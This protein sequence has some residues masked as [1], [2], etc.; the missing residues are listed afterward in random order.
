M[1]AA[2]LHD[3]WLLG[4][5]DDLRRRPLEALPL[6]AARGPVVSTRVLH[7]PV[8]LVSHP[9]GVQQVFTDVHTFDKRT[10][11]YRALGLI[12]GE[13]LV[14][15]DGEKW[16]R[17]RRIAQPAFHRR[18]IEG[19]AACMTDAAL[20]AA[21]EWDEAARR[22]EPV[23]AYASLTRLSLR[24]ACES[25]L[26]ADETDAV[27]RVTTVFSDL[28]AK[29]VER[30]G[31]PLSVPLWIPTPANRRFNAALAA[32][33]E[34]VYGLIARRRAD[35][36]SGDRSDILS[37]FLNA[38]DEETGEGMSDRELRD[39][40]ST[41]LVAG[42]ETT[43]AA[44]AWTFHLL[45]T[46]PDAADRLRAELDE[47][48]GGREPT[49]ADLGRLPWTRQ[50]IDESMRVYPPVWLLGRNATKDTEVMGHPVRKGDN[51]L[52][53]AWVVHRH[54]DLWEEPTAFRPERF[55]PERRE[56]LHKYAYFPFLGGPRQ[57]IGHHFALLEMQLVLATLGRFRIAPAPGHVVE[58]EPVLT[59]RPKRGVWLTVASG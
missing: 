44:L 41:M 34:I 8:H 30:I 12:V 14:T 24:V 57:C 33:D 50:V 10:V 37:L 59:L 28:S 23:D 21:A 2:P 17:Q 52:A 55:A 1:N 13:G 47:V 40:L 32:L 6:L 42:F 58:P 29:A 16:K 53:S 46:H 22:G 19:Y 5:A 38:R 4:F 43:A 45:S 31:D 11:S 27:R 25:L 51:V 26:G 56:A 7:M 9:D 3:H 54:P 18:R 20:A 15:S 36:T 49:V 39:E 35:P 48:L